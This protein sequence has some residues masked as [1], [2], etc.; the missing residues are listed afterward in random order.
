MPSYL[1]IGYL[2]IGLLV[3]ASLL[4]LFLKVSRLKTYAKSSFFFILIFALSALSWM[5]LK[6]EVASSE[7]WYF[8]LFDSII[9]AAKGFALGNDAETI[10]ESSAYA[11]LN[12]STDW[13]ALTKVMYLYVSQGLC[14]LFASTAV[15][16]SLF[17]VAYA[18]RH[19]RQ[20]NLSFL[21]NL[22]ARSS[23][24]LNV[25][26]TDLDFVH[27]KPFL[28]NMKNNKKSKIKV[29]IPSEFYATQS[30][31]ELLEILRLNGY[32]AYVE[33]INVHVIKKFSNFKFPFLNNVNFYCIRF[34]DLDNLSF[35]HVASK[36]LKS[37]SGAYKNRHDTIN[38][39]VSYQDEEFAMNYDLEKQSH[40][41][42]QLVNEYDW[43]ACK[44]V[45]ENP[46]TR[47]ISVDPNRL[48]SDL[49]DKPDVHVHFFG[50]GNINRALLKRMF[51]AYQLPYDDNQVH[52]HIL[53]LRAEEDKLDKSFL[54]RYISFNDKFKNKEFYEQ[55]NF[56]QFFHVK[57]I[58][59]SSDEKLLSYVEEQVKYIYDKKSE[60]R[61]K[62]TNLIFIA[63]SD[64]GLNVE[65]ANKTRMLIQNVSASYG[66]VLTENSYHKSF[67]I[68]PY[69]KDNSFF[70][71][72]SAV[73][74]DIYQQVYQMTNE[75][76]ALT[77]E[78][79]INDIYD[80]KGYGKKF[81]GDLLYVFDTKYLKDDKNLLKRIKKADKE[82]IIQK[83][84]AIRYA[85]FKREKCPVVVIGRGGYISDP[86]RDMIYKLA[87]HVN[88][89]YESI[90]TK[91]SIANLKRKANK[92]DKD[93]VVLDAAKNKWYNTNYQKKQSN[94]SLA[95]TFQTKLNLI[96]YELKWDKDGV[97]KKY[98]S[99]KSKAGKEKYLQEMMASPRYRGY[100]ATLKDT[101]LLLKYGLSEDLAKTTFDYTRVI[102]NL[103]SEM[104]KR[105]RKYKKDL[106]LDAVKKEFYEE[107]TKSYKAYLKEDE[108]VNPKIINMV[109]DY[110]NLLYLSVKNKD[111]DA[112]TMM[113]HRR[114]YVDSVRYGVVPRLAKELTSKMKTKSADEGSN[115]CVTT[116][117]GLLKYVGDTIKKMVEERV[118][119][120]DVTQIPIPDNILAENDVIELANKD[121]YWFICDH[122]TGIPA[123]EGY[124]YSVNVV[125]KDDKESLF[126]T[127]TGKTFV[128]SD[129][130]AFN[131]VYDKEKDDTH[132]L[133]TNMFNII[134][135][136]DLLVYK[137]IKKLKTLEKDNKDKSYRFV[138]REKMPRN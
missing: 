55:Y 63:L 23:Y 128:P 71:R 123:E 60:D 138:I 109:K 119:F 41:A 84:V 124:K 49:K 95:L 137:D 6:A 115:F 48:A 91:R 97:I 28:E 12:G 100:F 88:N 70:K 16:S 92:K 25:L 82:N 106:S 61:S 30:G 117:A 89:N 83:A 129:I 38:F 104:A 75:K 118:L 99:I 127:K 131:F 134:F 7:Q 113:E 47:F 135:G 116:S 5:L 45:Y 57:D 90:Y 133:F 120:L 72:S 126:L 10:Y 15:V 18:K 31:T 101:D 56:D 114:W 24:S 27:V 21:G 73:D 102:P 54:A 81:N 67:I 77:V 3:I 39:Y 34:A 44:F 130:S 98:E 121:N 122:N 69:V 59:L 37:F 107:Y 94:I 62:V 112:L 96:G 79:A 110:F 78:E 4:F 58:D 136:Y 29:I 87:M 105:L 80:N 74:A 22:S 50:F 46:I 17:K 86:L 13:Y 11:A 85:Q 43:T 32:D 1:S 8:S 125:S 9:R 19:N 108:S 111:L 76:P 20:V 14:L 33:S 64:M 42:I 103:S 36:Y 132:S 66:N 40:G 68:Y 35:A 53:D 52:Y 51:S 65:I 2:L 26:I 93:K